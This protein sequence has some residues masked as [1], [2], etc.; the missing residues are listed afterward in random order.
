M[1]RVVPVCFRDVCTKIW[2]LFTFSWEKARFPI[3]CAMGIAACDEISKTPAFSP[4]GSTAADRVKNQSGASEGRSRV[5]GAF[6]F[7]NVSA[8]F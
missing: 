2:I 1:G 4:V 6:G 3:I 7:C 5:G 8:V